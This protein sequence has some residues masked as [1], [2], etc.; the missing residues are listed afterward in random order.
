MPSP[1]DFPELAPQHTRGARLYADR[2][3]LLA[4]CRHALGGVVTEVGVA[5][6]EFSAFILETLRPSTFYAIDI[7]DM[8]KAPSHWGIPS[9]V[10]FKGMTHLDFYRHR[11]AAHG[12]SVVT[13][14]GWSHDVLATHA[15]ASMDLI[16]IDA[17]HAYDDVKRDALIACAKLKAGGTLIFN[18]YTMHDHF[19]NTPYGVVQVVNE[20]VVNEGWHVTGFALQKHMFCDIAI[21]REPASVPFW[22]RLFGGA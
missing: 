17:G 5:H 4:S 10:M 21:R 18:D 22:Q 2:K 20:L 15:D 9:E 8:H 7:F 11:F 6:G 1:A 19:Q 13:Q 14:Q 12:A 3:G 16:Y